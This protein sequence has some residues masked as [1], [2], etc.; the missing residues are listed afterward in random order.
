MGGVKSRFAWVEREDG[1][2]ANWKS[3]DLNPTK[4]TKV[5]KSIC[6]NKQA[7]RHGLKEPSVVLA[8]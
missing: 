7:G 5:S 1:V 4:K 2:K 8:F 3:L 6:T